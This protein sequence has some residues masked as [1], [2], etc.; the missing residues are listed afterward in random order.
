MVLA[1]TSVTV[2][3]CLQDPLLAL[4]GGDVAKAEGMGRLPAVTGHREA[5]NSCFINGYPRFLNRDIQSYDDEHL[6]SAS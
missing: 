1:P 5:Q 4:R 6:I 2:P 3:K